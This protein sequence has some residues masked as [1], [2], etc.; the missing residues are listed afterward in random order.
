MT[1][2]T[3]SHPT[4]HPS[5]FVSSGRADVIRRY[6]AVA[7]RLGRLLPEQLALIYEQKWFNLYVPSSYG[8]LD[9]S[10][11]DGLQ[12]QEGLAWA[13][14]S[15]GWTVTLCSG[16]NWFIRCLQP[17]L[18][19]EVFRDPHV[20]L[21]G[22]GRPSGVANLLSDGRYEVRGRWKYATGAPHATAF[23]ANCLI[24]KDGVPCQDMDGSPMVRAF[25]FLPPE[26]SIIEDWTATGMI[27]TA[28][29]SFSVNRLQ[30][31]SNRCFFIDP[32][33]DFLAFAESTLAVNSS[34]MATRFLDLAG[35]VFARRAETPATGASASAS[36]APGSADH[37]LATDHRSR[38]E[39]SMHILRAA[40]ERLNTARQEFYS[41]L[42][43][44]PSVPADSPSAVSI[45]SRRLA[46]TALRVVDELYPWCGLIAA[47][48]GSVINR[49]WRDLHT[50]SQHGLLLA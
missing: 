7:E 15:F 49:V 11:P 31:P 10:L 26:V 38:Q 29:H 44:G 18:A 46:A 19:A 39:R 43:A 30:V 2:N 22:S 4:A 33:Q 50:A 32:S 1:P 34:G 27:A 23:T 21:A 47:T 28:S 13:D 5:A 17:D 35:E 24:S 8:G 12:L 16:A 14:G 40:T 20:C 9:L 3:P 37:A 42:A 48:P 25:L 36:P 6:A 45:A 41:A